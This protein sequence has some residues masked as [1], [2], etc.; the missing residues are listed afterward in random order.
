MNQKLISNQEVFGSVQPATLKIEPDFKS[1]ILYSN[2][3][4]SN[5]PVEPTGE[6]LQILDSSIGSV[7][8]NVLIQL[9]Q[10][11]AVL[12]GGPWYIDLINGIVHVHNRRYTAEPVSYYCYQS[13]NGEVLSAA[14]RLVDQY[15]SLGS[16]RTFM[17]NLTKG[18][19]DFV[20]ALHNQIEGE[21][22]SAINDEKS[23][24]ED[25]YNSTKTQLDKYIK[26]RLTER[27]DKTR[28]DRKVIEIKAQQATKPW[29]RGDV[30]AAKTK[31]QFSTQQERDALKAS[32]K[33]E[34]KDNMDIPD[35]IN[36]ARKQNGDLDAALKR[37]EQLKANPDSDPA[38]VE[39]S[40]QFVYQVAKGRKVYAGTTRGLY[41]EFY[42]DITIYD[43]A[44]AGSGGG[45]G[46]AGGSSQ[47]ANSGPPGKA[48]MDAKVREEVNRL[49][50]VNGARDWEYIS[51]IPGTWK[52]V[53]GWMTPMKAKGHWYNAFESGM[54][55]KYKAVVKVKFRGYYGINVYEDLSKIIGGAVPR[56]QPKDPIDVGK[57]LNNA[58]NN[59]G[60][61]KKE[62]RLECTLLVVGNP[63][64]ETCQQ[65]YLSNVSKNYSGLWYIARAIHKLEPSSGY[66]TECLLLRSMPKKKT[67]GKAKFSTQPTQENNTKDNNNSKQES[68]H[69]KPK[70]NAASTTSSKGKSKSTT[71]GG[72]QTQFLN[73]FEADWI[74]QNVRQLKNV[75]DVERVATREVL[76]IEVTRAATGK[77][78]IT[79]DR[80]G[81]A[82]KDQASVM[83]SQNK[84]DDDKFKAKVLK[85]AG[86]KN[87][88]DR[89]V[90]AWSKSRKK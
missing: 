51:Y 84:L 1:T 41:G 54:Y 30:K 72:K 19:Q 87:K 61:H 85:S 42:K 40:R 4:A 43:Y 46:S 28:V 49:L 67:E 8:T 73:A 83:L 14:F 7:G 80:K 39:A 38:E 63:H 17:D 55:M 53:T 16:L 71:S 90:K 13:E 35:A 50:E 32:R 86:L 79:M 5:S 25:Y 26:D 3:F 66:T 69:P 2:R 81:V 68:R 75:K 82:S 24:I 23:V 44:H 89:I 52:P 74:V 31:Y 18:L 48:A 6:L 9:K 88:V 70:P 59:L 15:K 45:N 76:D 29:V 37:Y 60:R 58:K 77:S 11:L 20:G 65:V 78:P 33:K 22:K 10:K 57:F 27:S 34:V 21:I 56:K 62:T 47:F 12:E 64:L 36:L